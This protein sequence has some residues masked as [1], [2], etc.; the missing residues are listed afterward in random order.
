MG[1]AVLSML[2]ECEGDCEPK[3]YRKLL[4]LVRKQAKAYP[5]YMAESKK[6]DFTETERLVLQ[7]IIAG[8]DNAS[9]A[10]AMHIKIRT[11]KFHCTNIYQKLDVT[12]RAQAIV[13][14][15]QEDPINRKPH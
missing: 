10:E 5:N 1:N 2:K 6:K 15:K 3:F 7:Y 12:S 9:I 4:T 11:V 14:A 8:F 13:A